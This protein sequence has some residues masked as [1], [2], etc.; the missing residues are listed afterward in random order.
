LLYHLQ[1]CFNKFSG[2]NKR[3]SKPFHSDKYFKFTA[4]FALVKVVNLYI[5]FNS[6]K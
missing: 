6:H 5:G 2:S 4:A 3:I 1:K